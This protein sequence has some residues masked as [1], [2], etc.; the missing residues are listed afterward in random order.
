MED[1][2]SCVDDVFAQGRSGEGQQ[3][4]AGHCPIGYDGLNVVCAAAGYVDFV[5]DDGGR[6]VGTRGGLLFC[7]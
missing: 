5:S 3:D 1:G 6:E 2:S 4:V 7:R